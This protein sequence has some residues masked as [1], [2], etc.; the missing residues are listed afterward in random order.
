MTAHDRYQALMRIQPV[1]RCPLQ[2][3]G[4]WPATLQRWH[5][6]TGKST[7]SLMAYHRE[8]DPESRTDVDFAMIPAYEERVVA[9]DEQ[10]VTR[11]DRM[12]Q[13]YREFKDDPETSNQQRISP[14]SR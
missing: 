7:A 10:T 12:G 4:P 1:D 3:W 5:S 13:T 6:D 9:A 8:C 11:T 14:G 2:E